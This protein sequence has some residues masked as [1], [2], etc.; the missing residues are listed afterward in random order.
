MVLV[1]VGLVRPAAMVEAVHA[2]LEDFEHHLDVGAA[3]INDG[4]GIAAEGSA[5]IA[6]HV[7]NGPRGADDDDRGRILHAAEQIEDLGFPGGEGGHFSFI[8]VKPP[9]FN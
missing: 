6:V 2:A 9:L 8:N 4:E 5:H 3:A 1:R 7:P